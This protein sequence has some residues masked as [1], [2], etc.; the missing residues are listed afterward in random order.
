MLFK[1][2]IEASDEYKRFRS[3]VERFAAGRRFP[4]EKWFPEDRIYIPFS[5]TTSDLPPEEA[6]REMI[7]TLNELLAEF[8]GYRKLGYP[9][10][11]QGYELVDYKRGL[12]K[13]KNATSK[14][15]YK[16]GNFFDAMSMIEDEKLQQQLARGEISP[17][18]YQYE[19]GSTRNY[20]RDLAKEF[21]NDPNRAKGTQFYVVISSNPH[22]LASMSTGRGWT[23]CMNLIDGSNKQK[24]YCE[25]AG[26]GFIAYL[27]RANDKEIKNPIAR[28]HIRRLD[29]KKGE[30]VA[31]PEESVYGTEVPG[32]L[33][34][35]KRWL[36]SK[37]GDVRPGEYALRGG[38]YSDTFER[39]GTFVPPR[40]VETIQRWINKWLGFKKTENKRKYAQYFIQALAAFLRSSETFPQEFVQK[41][42]DFIFSD[43]IIP[44]R[45]WTQQ[46]N[47]FKASFALK[48]PELIT[49]EEFEEAFT[50]APA[51]MQDKLADQ[52]PQYMTADMAKHIG[53]RG[54]EKFAAKFGEMGGALKQM[55]QQAIM[56]DLRADNPDFVA[57]P[58]RSYFRVS[59]EITDLLDQ[60]LL[61]RPI[62]EPLIRRIVSFADN[63]DQLK[64]KIK[65]VSPEAQEQINRDV[66]K[67]KDGI[68]R[69]IAHIFAMTDSDTPTVVNFY[70][71]IL[72]KWGE[73]GGI[74]TLGMG[75]ANLGN[76]GR[77]LLPFLK[78][79]MKEVEEIDVSEKHRYNEELK[80]R[81]LENF[82]YVIDSIEKGE[83]S[84]KYNFHPGYFLDATL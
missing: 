49:Q 29:N 68:L 40:D 61:F 83:R 2:W 1:L 22:D 63:I 77:E 16:I 32:F 57:S 17:A 9:P 35:V 71:S 15:V 25:V 30:S 45:T 74:G 26:G 23:S 11:P 10:S 53:L 46:T 13:P 38:S 21:Q 70:K 6:E 52:F 36:Q 28:V 33:D 20:F 12:I 75:L 82:R 60:A 78:K 3:K 42:K 24:V 19:I 55:A 59:G 18:K 64:L 14:N 84:R 8:P 62:P 80:E 47:Q 73:L 27:V 69:H 51:N 39:E 58:N 44:T 79:K 48:Y 54:R 81:A 56:N 66:E 5:P 65:A 72:P 7:E 41:I 4:F 34:T 31:L 50:S 37:Q 67:V 43:K 76:N